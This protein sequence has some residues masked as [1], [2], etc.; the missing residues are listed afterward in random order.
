MSEKRILCT[1]VEENCQY[2]VDIN[3]SADA[4]ECQQGFYCS[5]STAWKPITKETC[6]ICKEGRYQGLTREQTIYKMAKAL[7]QMDYTECRECSD[8]A[9]KDNPKE[10]KDFL[11]DSN[12]YEQAEAGLNALL[13][14]NNNE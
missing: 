1:E 2:L 4:F 5:K 13:E 8:C 7:C 11:K 12:F 10:C 3:L 9:Y 6:K 14:I